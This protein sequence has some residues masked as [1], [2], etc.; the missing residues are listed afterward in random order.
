VFPAG[1]GAP[2]ISAHIH[3]I[4]SDRPRN[5]KTLLARLY[6]DWLSLRGADRLRVFDT[7][8]P[9]GSIIQWFPDN[10]T[11]IDISRTIDHVKMLDEMIRETDVNYVVDLQSSL[12]DR[13]FEIFHDIAFDEGAA[14]AGI[15]VAV[16]FILDRSM[17]SIEAAKRTRE[18]L[19]KAE[20]ILVRNDA[21]G[22]ILHEPKAAELYLSIP[23]DRDIRIPKLSNEA[24]DM[25]E[26]LGFSFAA[27]L[28]GKAEEV[29]VAARF[30]IWNFLEAIYNQRQAGASGDTLLI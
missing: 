29:P 16:F 2:A 6:A 9:H 8:V 24:R 28:T 30:E 5:G 10:T 26:R 1:P 12:L 22:D 18:K 15:G 21:I 17:R 13:F 27:F 4:C 11:L 14:E 3:I 7:D 25:V 23:R 19:R 20:F